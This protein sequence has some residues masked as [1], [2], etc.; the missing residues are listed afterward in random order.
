MRTEK[1]TL[2]MLTS[3][4]EN[5]DLNALKSNKMRKKRIIDCRTNEYFSDV[6]V[7]KISSNSITVNQVLKQESINL[8]LFIY[9]R[10]PTRRGLCFTHPSSCVYASMIDNYNSLYHFFFFS[11]LLN[12]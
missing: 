1:K 8:F 4:T 5:T 7:T 6:I 10:K 3:F 2:L 9:S 11:S 12:K